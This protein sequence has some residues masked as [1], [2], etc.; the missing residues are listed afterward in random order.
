[1]NNDTVEIVYRW[2]DGREEVRYRRQVGT[3]DARRLMEEV[4]EL[5]ARAEFF[6]YETPY[7]FRF[8]P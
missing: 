5:E 6:G 8:V 4:E 3:E 2:P 1:M 7:S